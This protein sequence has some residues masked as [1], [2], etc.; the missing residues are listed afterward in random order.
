MKLVEWTN[1]KGKKVMRYPVLYGRARRHE[2]Q[3]QAEERQKKYDKLTLKEKIAQ[4]VPDSKEHVR[5][6]KKGEE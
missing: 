6:V 2:R 4:A 1:K 5:L 3:E